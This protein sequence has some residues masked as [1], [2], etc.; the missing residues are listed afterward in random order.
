MQGAHKGV[1]KENF[2]DMSGGGGMGCR[3]PPADTEETEE[4]DEDNIVHPPINWSNKDKDSAIGKLADDDIKPKK[5]LPT[6]KQ[7]IG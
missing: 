4:R 5:E 7:S 1:A 2:P 3:L 6:S